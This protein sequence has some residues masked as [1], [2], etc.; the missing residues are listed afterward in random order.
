MINGFI[1]LKTYPKFSNI[2]YFSVTNET[3]NKPTHLHISVL[4]MSW[5][6]GFYKYP[7]S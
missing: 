1:F 5:L 2:F 3:L 7:N 4:I 6:Y